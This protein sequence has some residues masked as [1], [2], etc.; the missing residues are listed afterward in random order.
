MDVGDRNVV[1]D[2]AEPV[3][4]LDR[5]VADDHDQPVGPSLDRRL[6]DVREQ[7]APRNVDESLPPS[8]RRGDCHAR[9]R[10]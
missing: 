4:G 9:Q 8:A 7:G 10:G 2:T 1:K 3:D 6:K 5:L